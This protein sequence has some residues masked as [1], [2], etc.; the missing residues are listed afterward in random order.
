MKD[1]V[2]WWGVLFV[3][4]L[5]VLFTTHMASRGQRLAREAIGKVD[6]IS[7][8]LDDVKALI[9]E[10]RA[11]SERASKDVRFTLEQLAK[12]IGVN[13][14]MIERLVVVPGTQGGI[15]VRPRE[16]A[17]S[18]VQRPGPEIDSEHMAMAI[19]AL[20]GRKEDYRMS[21]SPQQAET[22]EGLRDST[23]ELIFQ[24][25]ELPGIENDDELE[26]YKDELRKSGEL[27]QMYDGIEDAL[28]TDMMLNAIGSGEFGV[29]PDAE[30]LKELDDAQ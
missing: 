18:V 17:D 16:T 24:T 14:E 10:N 26:A 6:E 19:Q 22:L 8:K 29:T 4:L 13:R 2:K 23:V 5:S 3:S 28:L 21:L 25:T 15:E 30:R 11:F 12:A 20:E 9:V 7:T 1:D 27:Q